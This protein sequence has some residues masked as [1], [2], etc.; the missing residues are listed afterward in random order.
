MQFDNP[1]P[2][3]VPEVDPNATESLDIDSNGDDS[4]VGLQGQLRL[5]VENILNFRSI[6]HG[7][8]Y[9]VLL[10]VLIVMFFEVEFGIINN[11]TINSLMALVVIL[12]GASTIFRSDMDDK[13]HDPN[14]VPSGYWRFII[15]I[16]LIVGELFLLVQVSDLVGFIP[17]NAIAP[18]VGLVG[19]VNLAVLWKFAEEEFDDYLEPHSALI[20]VVSNYIAMVV[21]S[22]VL[23]IIQDNLPTIKLI[24]NVL[25]LFLFLFY[26]G[27]FWTY[28]LFDRQTINTL[29]RTVLSFLISIMVLP[30]S[31]VLL[32]RI[33]LQITSV[34]I[35]I[36]NFVLCT[37]GFLAYNARP[38]F[39]RWLYAG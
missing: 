33:G 16:F 10:L 29:T 22:V 12:G 2:T 32:N 18:L 38:R 27:F 24:T 11:D 28:A 7:T 15:F 36:T 35:V 25:S 34:V 3:F 31:I 4:Y 5:Q 1:M 39:K 14:Y 21:L 17:I 8:F 13:V 19:A 23:F 26:S 30:L 20:T 9:I 37:S 6:L